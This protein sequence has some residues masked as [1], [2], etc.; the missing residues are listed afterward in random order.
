MEQSNYDRQ[1]SLFLIDGFTN[2][3]DIGYNGSQVRQS[4]S[5]NIPFTVGNE[6]DMWEKIMK[7]VKGK[8]YAGPFNEIPFENYIQS[9]IGLVPKAGNKTRLI[10]H[11]SFEFPKEEEGGGSVNGCTPRELCS[12]TYN[13]LDDA[14]K[15]CPLM[16]EK[17]EIINGH[18]IIYLGKTD[19]SMAFRVLPL[20]KGCFQWLILKAIDPRDGKV[21]YF[22]EK[23]LPF[24]A[25]ISCSHYQRFSNALKHIL[26]FRCG[27]CACNAIMNYLDDFLFIAILKAICNRLINE[28]LQLCGELQVLVALE[29]TEWATDSCIIVFLGI[30]LYGRRLLISIPLEKQEKALK[31]LNNFMDCKKATIKQAQALTGYLNFLTKAIPAGRTFMRCMYAKCASFEVGKNGRRLKQHHHVAID[32]EFKFDC[33]V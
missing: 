1:E 26:K 30:L 28:F 7:E 31:L 18:K 15:N 13:G 24:R 3:F 16:S 25:S 32:R 9:P 29:K 8:R 12:V 19:L 11:L 33:N 4:T 6:L 23:C 2:G 10:F 22:V 21:K 14:I 20:K 17:A 5:D 27:D